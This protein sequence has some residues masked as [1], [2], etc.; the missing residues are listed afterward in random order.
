MLENNLE[1]IDEYFVP[2]VPVEAG[3]IAAGDVAGGVRGGVASGAGAARVARQ[4]EVGGRIS[5]V[6]V[7]VVQWLPLGVIRG[8]VAFEEATL[9]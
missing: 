6:L 5:E 7:V 3:G 2:S 4:P 9:I 1:S 8:A